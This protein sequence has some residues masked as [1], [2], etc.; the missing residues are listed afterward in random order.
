MISPDTRA[1]DCHFF[2]PKQ[3]LKHDFVSA[4]SHVVTKMHATCNCQKGFKRLQKESPKEFSLAIINEG[5][6]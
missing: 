4:G 6:K 2:G 3:F 5:F 1:T